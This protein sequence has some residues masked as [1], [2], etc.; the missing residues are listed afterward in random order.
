VDSAARLYSSDAV[1]QETMEL[2]HVRAGAEFAIRGAETQLQGKVIDWL[3]IDA[4]VRRE[5][6]PWMKKYADQGISFVDA[7][8]FVL[9]RRKNIRHVFGFGRPFIAAGFRLWPV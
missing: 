2:L 1:F 9:M 3:A 5:S 4:P 7:T 8:S 6:L